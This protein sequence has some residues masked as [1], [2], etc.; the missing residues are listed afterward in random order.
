VKSFVS[1]KR[2]V[3]IGQRGLE[4][5]TAVGREGGASLAVI[6]ITYGIWIQGL[7]IAKLLSA[8][9]KGTAPNS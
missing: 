4:K 5:N 3:D 6:P 8:S 1:D 2:L 9:Q 7:S